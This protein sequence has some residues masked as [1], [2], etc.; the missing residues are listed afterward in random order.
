MDPG[1]SYA[2]AARDLFARL[3]GFPVMVGIS[4]QDPAIYPKPGPNALLQSLRY[5]QTGWISVEGAFDS[6]WMQRGKSL[7]QNMR[8]QHSKLAREHIAATFDE[9]TSPDQ[10]PQAIEDYGRLESA[11]WKS[12]LGTAISPTNRQGKFYRGVLEDYCRAGAGRIFRLSFND[13]PVAV[14]LCIE[15][16]G[17][18]VLLKTT[19]DE[20]VNGFSPSSLL[21]EH[22]Y[23]QVFRRSEIR[24]I[25][26]FGPQMQWT[27]RWTPWTRVLFHV[28]VFRNPFLRAARVRGACQDC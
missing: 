26:F 3:P 17:M 1:L 2:D 21:K 18:H 8:T 23:R 5:I 20:A 16:D 6:Y 28:N 7:R 14:D 13:R 24:S 9:I 10:V 19:Y 22:A 25:E 4:Q 11:G 27:A 15:G 12:Q